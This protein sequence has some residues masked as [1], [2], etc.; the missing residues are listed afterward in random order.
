MAEYVGCTVA[1]TFLG[2]G[3]KKFGGIVT[4]LS[5]YGKQTYF[6][7]VYDDGDC[8]DISLSELKN[9]LVL[10]PKAAPTPKAAAHK[11]APEPATGSKRKAEEPAPKKKPGRPP[12]AKP[13]AAQEEVESEQA[14]KASEAAAAAVAAP[15][16]KA[17][18]QP[19]SPQPIHPAAATKAERKA[20]QA[21][22]KACAAGVSRFS[23]GRAGPSDL[24][25]D[26]IP[27]QSSCTAAG[28]LVFTSTVY[29][30]LLAG[31]DDEEGSYELQAQ[32]VLGELGRQ[33]EAVGTGK[34]ALLDVTAF[35]KD[36]E[37]GARGFYRAWN[38][39]VDP[40]RLPALSVAESFQF[41]DRILVSVKGVA[42]ISS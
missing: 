19:T 39:W 21:T 36:T 15:A 18:K 2:Y 1:K 17:A 38:K 33:L 31:I 34:A 3:S 29:P 41:D 26:D 24:L 30:T 27:K 6:H 14:K 37:K 23:L 9:I 4:E 40:N 11:A 16:P 25:G 42:A 10:A 20:A 32:E 8:E 35:V 7:I 5:K 13:A 28:G 12:K 22:A